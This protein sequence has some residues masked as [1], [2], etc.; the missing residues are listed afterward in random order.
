VADLEALANDTSIAD[1]VVLNDLAATAPDERVVPAFDASDVRW[2]IDV[3]TYASHPRVRYYLEYFQGIARSRMEVFL[4]RGA[5]FEPMIRARFQE[6]GLPGDLGYLALI[7]SGY[8][9][10]AVSHSYAVGMWQFMK[11]TGLGYGLR[12]D[13]WVD[14]RRDPI[15]ATDAAAR[16]AAWAS[17]SG[18][19]RPTR[20]RTWPPTRWTPQLIRSTPPRRTPPRPTSRPTMRPTLIPWMPLPTPPT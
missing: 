20:R 6:E 15:K 5:K 1:A 13:S 3:R 12:V 14:E 4:S 19:P 18:T 7:E 17:S 10:N 11:G 9:S 16:H 8:S 2:D